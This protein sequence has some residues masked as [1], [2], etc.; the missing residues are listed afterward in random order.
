MTLSPALTLDDVTCACSET[1]DKEICTVTAHA[2]IEPGRHVTSTSCH[3]RTRSIDQRTK[4]SHAS[5][6]PLYHLIG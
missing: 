1:M 3:P 6:S 2:V 4:W 5:E